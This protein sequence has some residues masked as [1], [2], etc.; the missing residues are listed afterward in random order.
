MPRNEFGRSIPE[1]I[2]AGKH[3]KMP[4]MAPDVLR[5]LVDGGVAALRFLPQRHKHD[6]IEVAAQPLAEFFGRAFPHGTWRR[7][8]LRL[9]I[10]IINCNRSCFPPRRRAWS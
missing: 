8:V 4:E 9:F 3:R 6:V 7:T 5:K 10:A 2:F 1:C